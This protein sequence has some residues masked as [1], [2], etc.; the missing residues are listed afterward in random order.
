MKK[1]IVLLAVICAMLS[2]VGLNTVQAYPNIEVE[3]FVDPGMGVDNLD[4]TTTFSDVTY[5]FDVVD[6]L[7]GAEMSAI[8]LEFENDVFSS[9]GGPLTSSP[10]DW[11]YSATP[12]TS[13]VYLEGDAGSTIAVGDQLSFTFGSLTLFNDALVP[14]NLLWQEGHD[15]W[16]QSWNAFD[17]AGGGDGGSTALVPEPG[18]LVL[19]GLGL[20][21]LLYV[22]RSKVFSI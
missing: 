8:S 7:G 22:R 1:V 5:W 3:G 12:S 10:A 16:G 11:T 13:S 18:T 2:F 15:I 17:N 20:S 14:G 4:G 6:A 9:W 21:G 19:L